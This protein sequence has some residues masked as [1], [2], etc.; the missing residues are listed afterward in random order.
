VLSGTMTVMSGGAVEF[1]GLDANNSSV[2]LLSG[3]TD[4]L[5]SGAFL[6][7]GQISRGLTLVILSGGTAL[8]GTVSAGALAILETGGQV[9]SD[10]TGNP[11]FIRSGGTF[12]FIGTDNSAADIQPL[13]GATLEVA[14][15]A[16]FE[17]SSGS[18]IN[19]GVTVKVLSAGTLTLSGKT[20]SV[21][22]LVETLSSGS[23]FVSGRARRPRPSRASAGRQRLR[24][25]AACP[26]RCRACQA[27]SPA[28]ARAGPSAR[29]SAPDIRAS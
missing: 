21:G 15:G 5:G 4:E 10:G 23:I 25:P 2:K 14:S 11:L 9:T 19:A 24:W 22:T 29:W 28:G 18:G 16:T 13:S 12:E 3:A 20:I 8:G 7:G 6:S 27:P 1:V 17:A 26:A